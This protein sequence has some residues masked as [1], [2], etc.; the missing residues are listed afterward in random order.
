MDKSNFAKNF[1]RCRHCEYAEEFGDS[2]GVIQL[3]CSK[4]GGK[5]IADV[6]KCPIGPVKV[7]ATCI[8]LFDRVVTIVREYLDGKGEA[9]AEHFIPSN[10]G[11]MLA[12]IKPDDANIVVVIVE[13]CL[14]G[15]VYRWGNN[16]HGKFWEQ[17]GGTCGYY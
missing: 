12:D 2:E 15:T 11:M 3:G 1:S 10:P 14:C 16:N 5:W 13:D 17:I 7:D 4:L 8:P 9:T 6:K